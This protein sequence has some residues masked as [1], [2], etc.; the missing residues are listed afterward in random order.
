MLIESIESLIL[1][2]EKSDSF[3]SE[4]NRIMKIFFPE[5]NDFEEHFFKTMRLLKSLG[6]VYLKTPTNNE[7][8]KEAE[9]RRDILTYDRDNPLYGIKPDQIEI[10][11]SEKKIAKYQKLLDETK[12][13]GRK[14]KPTGQHLLI[15][16]KLLFSTMGKTPER[17]IHSNSKAK[18]YRGEFLEFC[19]KMKK[20]L[21]ELGLHLGASDEAIGKQLEKHFKESE[22]F[23]QNWGN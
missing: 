18:A 23:A 1:N 19:L 20:P 14:A 5:K 13:D 11:V 6:D 21:K 15:L 10:E 9:L 3:K 7:I 22:Y 17:P 8:R 2:A 16:L 12:R 4:L